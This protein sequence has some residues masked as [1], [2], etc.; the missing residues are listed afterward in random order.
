MTAREPRD[1]V[2][3]TIFDVMTCGWCGAI[4]SDHPEAP[5]HTDESP[6]CKNAFWCQRCDRC[7][8]AQQEQEHL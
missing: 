6:V 4:L 1:H 3:W 7:R 2:F 5:D 8:H